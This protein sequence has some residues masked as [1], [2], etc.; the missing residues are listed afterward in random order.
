MREPVALYGLWLT[1]LLVLFGD[2]CAEAPALTPIEYTVLSQVIG[3]GLP[4]DTQAIVISAVTTG[5]PN[6]LVPAD[7]DLEALAKKLDT[8]PKACELL[9]RNRSFPLTLAKRFSRF[10]VPEAIGNG[11]PDCT[12]CRNCSTSFVSLRYCVTSAINAAESILRNNSS[13]SFAICTDLL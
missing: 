2:A 6:S 5:D 4:A 13:A 9:V 3:H 7:A 12:A 11:L 10:N 8:A 1:L